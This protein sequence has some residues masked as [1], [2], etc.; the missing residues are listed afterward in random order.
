MKFVCFD[1]LGTLI[2]I[3]HVTSA[4]DNRF[5]GHGEEISA[6]WRTKQIDYS[7]LRAMSGEYI[8]FD[9]VTRDALEASL[10]HCHVPYTESDLT[11]LMTRYQHGVTFP[12]VDSVL[13]ALEDPWSILTNGNRPFIRAILDHA[14]VNCPD[15]HLMTSDQ[16]TTFKTSP[17]LYELAWHWAQ[18]LGARTKM[19]VIFV[20]GNQWDAIGA[21]WFGFTTFWVNRNGHSPEVL[22]VRP[23]YES[24]SLEELLSVIRGV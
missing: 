20:S 5:P 14:K 17:A 11:E 15:S 19:E 24:E 8:P 21:T 10:M 7:R 12:E 16:V 3:T 2:D 22:G 4:V 6:L 23:D 13:A 18:E 1:A 9:Q